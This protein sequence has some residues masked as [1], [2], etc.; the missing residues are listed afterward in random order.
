M[1]APNRL[2][3]SIQVVQQLAHV[4]RELVGTVEVAAQGACGGLVGAGRPTQAEVDAVGIQRG[5]RAELFGHLQRR[6]IGQHDAAGTDADALGATGDVADQHGRGRAG[7]AGHVVVFG[8]PVAAVALR[9]GVLGQFQ[10]VG[11][12][13]GG[14]TA[15][16][17][18]G[19]VENRQRD[20][21]R[22]SVTGFP[23]HGVGQARRPVTVAGC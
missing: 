9:I 3:P 21:Q 5:Q 16:A 14:V 15:L 7:D 1:R 10:H 17:D 2:E 20:H 8:Q 11:E 18:R 12:G 13:G 22:F 19:Q 6:V 23:M 4:L